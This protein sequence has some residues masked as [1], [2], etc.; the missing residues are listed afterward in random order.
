MKQN[1]KHFQQYVLRWYQLYGRHKLPWRLTT[2]PYKVLV[3]ELMLQQTQ[4]ERVI[5]KYTAF[6]ELFPDFQS[7]AAAQLSQ[8]LIAWQGLG[9]NRR[10]KFLWELAKQVGEFS[11]GVLPQNQVELQKL[12]GIGPYTSAAILAFAHNQPICFIETNIRTVFI[13]HFFSEKSIVADSEIM[14]LIGES[15]PEKQSR[16]WYW[17]LM[18]YGSY[19]KSVLPNPSRQSKHHQVQK[20]FKGSL[21]QVRGEI[22]RILAAAANIGSLLTTKQLSQQITK[23]DDRFMVALN[24]LVAEKLV[25]SEGDVVRLG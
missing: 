13:Y 2:D 1:L 17:A 10:P 11:E 20:K 15:L 24:Q 19:L 4:V 25:V 14:P 21:R 3:S 9:Y 23:L 8:V 22:I 18:D 16:V 12:P 6:L 5:P 7:L